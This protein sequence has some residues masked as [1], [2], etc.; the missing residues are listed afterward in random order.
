MSPWI[1][2]F[3]GCCSLSADQICFHSCA[4]TIPLSV[5]DILVVRHGSQIYGDKFNW[6]KSSW[7]GI[8]TSSILMGLMESNWALLVP[9][10]GRDIY[11]DNCTLWDTRACP[12]SSWC[13]DIEFCETGVWSWLWLL[14]NCLGENRSHKW[15]CFILKS[16][17]PVHKEKKRKNLH[18][19]K[20]KQ[21]RALFSS[22]CCLWRLL[23]YLHWLQGSQTAPGER[24][25]RKKTLAHWVT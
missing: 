5:S 23:V 19:N 20:K 16:Q 15:E 13:Q 25:H 1:A 2:Q 12:S 4:N 7:I 8:P 11:W 14:L 21:G 10:S 24:G 9:R 17:K 18:P 3:W 22:I 6:A